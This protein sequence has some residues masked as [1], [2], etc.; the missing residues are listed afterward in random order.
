MRYDLAI[1]GGGIAGAALARATADVGLSV[2]VLERELTFRDRV[3]GEQM[4]PWGVAEA[5]AL[6]LLDLMRGSGARDIRLWSTRAAGTPEMPPRNLVETTPYCLP[7]LDFYHPPMQ[8]AL[9]DAA[10][11]AGAEVRR[12]TTVL[13]IAPGSVPSVRTR[14]RDEAERSFEARLVI[15]ADGRN[16]GCRAWGGFDVQCDPERMV[17]AGTLVEGL[18]APEDRVSFFVN[19]SSGQLSANA[20]LG[21][22]RFR[23]YFGW[24]ESEN[25]NRRRRSLSGRRSWDEFVAGSAAAGAPADWFGRAELAGPLASFEA[26]DTWVPHPYRCGVALVGDAAS[27]NDPNFGAGLSLALRDVRVLR[28]HLLAGNDWDAAGHAYATEHDKHYGAIHRITGWMRTLLYDQAPEALAIRARALPRLAAEPSRR[29]DLLGLGPD[30]P[31][32]DAARRRLFAED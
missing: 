8:T 28:D 30:G 31:S 29:L 13:G 3:R 22:G 11:A 24:F 14:L 18:D 12:G 20:P 5:Q 10:E 26:A 32:D 15:G 6:G 1:I 16:S 2:L 9:L 27:S 19:S 7:A 21:G 23:S 4:H 17:I 25:G